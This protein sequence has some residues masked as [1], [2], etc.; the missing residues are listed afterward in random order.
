M[1]LDISVSEQDADI[2]EEP[3]AAIDITSRIETFSVTAS[4]P[5]V[6]TGER[7]LRGFVGFEHMRS[8]STLLDAPFSFS[9]G[10]I[11]GKA[12]GSTLGFGVEWTK[13]NGPHA[14]VARATAKVGVDAAG[15]HRARGWPGRGFRGCSIGQLQYVRGIAWRGS[16]LLVRGLVQLDGRPVARDVQAARRRPLQRPRLSRKPAR[17]R[18]RL[19]HLDRV[20]VSGAR[21]C[22]RSTPR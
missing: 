20:S 14:L 3:F 10:E 15:P 7:M 18:P 2:I 11:D 22:Q 5:F 4:R 12:R 6:D 21:R 17:S 16:R 19:R 13:R 1:T 8:E 9:A